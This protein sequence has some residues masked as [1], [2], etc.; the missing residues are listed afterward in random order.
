[1]GFSPMMNAK[2]PVSANNPCPMLRALVSNGH[3]PDHGTS[4]K[5][6]GNIAAR[7]SG[8][9]DKPD[10]TAGVLTGLV[11]MI[12]NGL[13]PLSIM[14]NLL[15]GVRFDQL[16]DGPLDKHGVGSGVLDARGNV[17]AAN[18]DRLDQFASAKTDLSGTSEPGL[19]VAEIVTMMDAN[20]A[21]ASNKRGA[22]DRRLMDGEFPLLLKMMGK[23][24]ISGRYL[25]LAELR[26]LISDQRLPAR[27]TTRLSKEC[28]A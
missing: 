26:T 15:R 13:N 5:H 3:V 8:T 28:L 7:L 20:F 24:G 11:A 6:I 27:V 16:R 19:D 17:D 12:A 25:S 14:R 2:Y 9:P 23:D 21:R 1:M 4:L 22:I 10:R 18:L